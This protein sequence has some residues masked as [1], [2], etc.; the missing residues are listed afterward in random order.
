MKNIL[1]TLAVIGGTAW[2]SYAQTSNTLSKD[3]LSTSPAN[4]AHFSF[5]LDGGRTVPGQAKAI[6]GAS[7][8][9]EV[10]FASHTLFTASVGYSYLVFRNDT[11][12]GQYNYGLDQKGANF[13]PVKV[14]VKHYLDDHFF[15]EGQV[16]AAI[17]L[18]GGNFINRYRSAY[19]YS[20]GFGYTFKNGL[21]LGVRYEDWK[22]DVK[23]SQAAMRVSYRFK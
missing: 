21:E 13:L 15:V 3:S 9:Y 8:K 19:I 2:S 12:N 22:R 5:G 7:F 23:I 18:S 6:L 10:P 17:L 1:L 11:R 4:G 16:G 20:A 14:G